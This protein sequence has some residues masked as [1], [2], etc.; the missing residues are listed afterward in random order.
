MRFVAERTFELILRW[1]AD[2]PVSAPMRVF[3]HF[4]DQQGHIRFQGDHDPP[5]PTTKW[6]GTVRS[7]AQVR[8]PQAYSP[9]DVFELRVG[10]Y[11]PGA[12]H[13]P[14]EGPEDSTG[15]IR[16]GTLQLEG[17][18][19]K[20]TAVRFVPL[21]PQPDPILCRVN[22]TAKPIAFGEVT[23]D[24]ACR[25]T[26]EGEALDLTPLPGGPKFTA[27]LR[28]KDLPWPLPDPRRAEALDE[29]GDVLRRVPLQRDGDELLLTCEPG[30]FAYRLSGA[31]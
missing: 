6:R 25:L 21:V 2:E 20:V 11:Q 3:V 14:L 4:V 17:R 1:E 12:P 29:E 31:R 26:R 13:P 8:V 28:W 15:R 9:G 30:V 27:R 5:I 19:E 10:L 22:P 24:G 23:T 7:S 18:A 16:L